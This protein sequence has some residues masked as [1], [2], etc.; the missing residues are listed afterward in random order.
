MGSLSAVHRN[1]LFLDGQHDRFRAVHAAQLLVDLFQ[2]K[3]DRVLADPQLPRDH[4]VG[5]APAHLLEHS[6]FGGR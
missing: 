2:M 3:F 4:L 1:D 6:Y 5:S